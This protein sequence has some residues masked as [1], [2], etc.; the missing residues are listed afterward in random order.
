M[1]GGD[2]TMHEL[3]VCLALMEQVRKVAAEHNARRVDKIFLR[4]GPLSGIEASLL[5]NAFPI[6]ATGTVAED[7]ILVI[8]QTEIVVR[9]TQCEAEST[10]MP[11]NL[12]CRQCGDFRTRLITGDA[13]MLERLELDLGKTPAISGAEH[14]ETVPAPT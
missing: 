4:I 1:M 3:S 8:E 13:M 9:C 7:A 5:K 2:R 6:A 12:L 14:R 10:V 11:N